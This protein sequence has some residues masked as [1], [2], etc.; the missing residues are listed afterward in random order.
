MEM[1][2]ILILSEILAA[3]LS[4]Y[5]MSEGNILSNI[6]TFIILG[7]LGSIIITMRLHDFLLYRATTKRQYKKAIRMYKNKFK[8]SPN[9]KSRNGILLNLVPLYFMVEDIDNA[10]KNIKEVD[11]LTLKKPILKSYY[12][13]LMAYSKYLEGDFEK[14]EDY[15][16]SAVSY[17]PLAKTVSELLKLAIS[18]KKEPN[19]NITEKF[20]S[21]PSD[22]DEYYFE[23]FDK[24][25]IEIKKKL[26]IS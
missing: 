6:L 16:E 5:D 21:L 19:I 13:L 8:I 24:L 26:K 11:F 1:I 12:Q 7:G 4:F 3:F 18:L 15:L 17:E 14:I 22:L 20:K 2:I 10:T 25:Y 9:S 23:P